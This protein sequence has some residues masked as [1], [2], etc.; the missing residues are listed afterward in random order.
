VS[1]NYLLAIAS[2]KDQWKQNFFETVVSKR[3]KEYCKVHNLEYI[4]IT[5]DVNPVRNQYFWYTSFKHEEIVNNVLNEGDGL[6]S[7]D[8]DA[9]IVD[10][11]K[12]LLPPDQKNFAYSIDTANT[13]CMGWS[14]FIKSEWTTN[15]LSLVNSQKRY[16]S[17]IDKV[18]FHE[19]K[20]T[21]DSFWREFAEQASWYSLAGIKRHSNESF[22]KLP[23]MGWHSDK[24]EWTIYS[25]DELYNNVH[26]FPSEYNVTELHGE[27][28]CVNYINKVKYD[29]VI[30][31][32]FAGGQKWREEWV[33]TKSLY[34]RLQKINLFKYINFYKIKVF[35]QKL[36]GFLLSKFK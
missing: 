16:D 9:I 7:I 5:S 27:S 31:R 34:F 13:H 1:K 4:E 22:W 8:A 3:N 29:D 24:D 23:D 20:K 36:K 15:M 35:F 19:G 30:I 32:H 33:N 25:L 2:Y 28:T 6:I 21:E 12:S 14:S 10:M 11:N 18:S 26:I 17:L